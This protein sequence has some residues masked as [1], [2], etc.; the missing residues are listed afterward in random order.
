[1]LSLTRRCPFH[2]IYKR[3][4]QGAKRR[5]RL[6]FAATAVLI[7]AGAVVPACVTGIMHQR[8]RALSAGRTRLT[9]MVREDRV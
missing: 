9:Q 2:L 8:A 3:E 4:T 7:I 1:V 5:A 6:Y